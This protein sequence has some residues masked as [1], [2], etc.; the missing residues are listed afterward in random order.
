M[1]APLGNLIQPENT[2][3][4]KLYYII[5]LFE[6]HINTKYLFNKNISILNTC[7][8]KTYQY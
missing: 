5:I 7:S 3:K 8:T 1:P 4:Q 6:K 2:R